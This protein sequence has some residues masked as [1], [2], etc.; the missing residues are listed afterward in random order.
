MSRDE[1]DGEPDAIIMGD[2]QRDVNAAAAAILQVMEPGAEW[3][4]GCCGQQMPSPAAGEWLDRYQ[5]KK[6]VERLTGRRG[7]VVNLALFR[8]EEGPLVQTDN[9]WRVC[10]VEDA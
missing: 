3:V 8:L 5:V 9:M 10:L 6:Q 1:S 7:A 2:L 4:C